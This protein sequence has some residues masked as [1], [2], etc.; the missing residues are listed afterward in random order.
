V[1]YGT[2]HF[3]EIQDITPWRKVRIFMNAILHD[4]SPTRLSQALDA[5]KVAFWTLLFSR[6][7]K[8][9]F[10]DDPGILWFE[11]E[12]RHDIFNRVLQT[13]LA[14]DTCSVAVECVIAYFQQ[15]RLPFLWHLGPSSS[16]ANLGSLLESSGMTYYE[17]E[18]GMAVDLLKFNE[19]LPV[20]SQLTIHLVTTTELLEQW[21][22]IWEF[23]SSEE[24]IRLWLTLYSNSC[25][26]QEGPLRL[27]LGMLDGEPVATS[28]VFFCAGVAAIGPVSTLPQHRRQGIGAAMTLK[29]LQEARSQGY[30]IGVLTSSPMGINIY[31]RIGFQQFCT[32]SLYLWH[33]SF[34]NSST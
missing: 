33:P 7:P 21:I 14:P 29:A 27:Y 4:F 15:H 13:S 25:P 26:D 20:A 22:R 30:R 34:G 32:S 11:T 10:H 1:Y 5:N 17:T 31:R 28:G 6:F 23:G 2:L 3:I 24:L 8:T 18:P 9:T 12:I 19:D 16:P